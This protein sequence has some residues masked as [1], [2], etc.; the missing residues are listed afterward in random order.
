MLR[1]A[2]YVHGP[3]RY[4]WT[5]KVLSERHEDAWQFNLIGDEE[6]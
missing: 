5:I 2:E 3:S 4:W 1:Y 6:V